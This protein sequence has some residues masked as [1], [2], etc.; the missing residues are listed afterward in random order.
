[1]AASAPS[2]A[3]ADQGQPTVVAAD[4]GRPTVAA[5]APTAPAVSAMVIADTRLHPNEHM[6]IVNEDWLQLPLTKRTS[7]RPSHVAMHRIAKT[8]ADNTTPIN[9]KFKLVVET[10]MRD[11]ELWSAARD[12]MNVNHQ[13]H[14]NKLM[15]DRKRIQ[16]EMDEA[17]TAREA[18]EQIER[19]QRR[20][21]LRAVNTDELQQEGLSRGPRG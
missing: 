18:Q 15:R 1:M 20:R 7:R 4:Q 6:I 13:A 17:E 11:P 2:A 12:I 10:A 16:R 19:N 8:L 14:V 21:V 3:S 5:T 9:E